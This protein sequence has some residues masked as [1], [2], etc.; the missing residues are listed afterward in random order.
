M[1]SLRFRLVFSY[2][3]IVTLTLALA[4]LAGFFLVRRQLLNGTDF[5]LDSEFKEI[6]VRLSTLKRDATGEDIE[7]AIGR[8]SRIDAPFY[9]FQVHSDPGSVLF[10]S[11]NLGDKLIPDLTPAR[12]DRAT[13]TLGDLGLLRVCE[14]RAGPLHVQI[15]TSLEYL[16]RLSQKFYRVLVLLVGIALVLGV[17]IGLLLCELTLRP[18]RVIEQTA[19]RIS[20]SNLNERIPL[21]RSRDEIARLAELLNAMFDRLEKSFE[22]IKQ[23]T[24]DFSHELR[25][26]LSIIGL[27]AEK[28]L[29]R[30]GLDPAIA[31]GLSEILAESRRLNRII[32]QLLTLAKAEAQT[33]PLNAMPASTSQFIEDFVEDASALAEAGGRRF[34]LVRNDEMTASFDSSWIRQVLFNLLSNA[35]KF[36]PANGRILLESTRQDQW[37]RLA[38]V[39]E[40]PGIPEAERQRIFERF[41]QLRQ[42]PDTTSGAGLGLAVSKSI[43]ELHHGTIGVAAPGSGT[44]SEFTV[45]LPLDGDFA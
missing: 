9:F 17:G 22:Q 6:E 2:S 35:I 1:K 36:S 10:R 41:R 44:G 18:L 37:W 13:V 29:N 5:L 23:F 14:Y 4:L 30:P 20:V 43:V 11:G 15:A 26:P 27:H 3:V 12:L 45:L 34:E 31:P 32:D 21:P 19:R 40:G 16:G 28:I 8:H 33:L 25:T 24:A 39:D 38:L 42:S 7:A